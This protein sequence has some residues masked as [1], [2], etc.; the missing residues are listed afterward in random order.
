MK[1]RISGKIK[2]L[3][4]GLIIALVMAGCSNGDNEAAGQGEGPVEIE[5]WYGLGGNLGENMER[6]IEEFNSS[7][8]EVKVTGVAQG[9]YTET[10][11]KLQAA[12]A[13]K[14]V[15][16]AVLMGGTTVNALAEKEALAPMDSFIS[17]A[18]EFN[19]EDF[20]DSF[21]SQ[22][23]IDEKQYALP[24]YGTTQVMYYRDDVFKELGISTDDLSNWETLR[25]AAGK[26]KEEKGIF[27][28]MPMWGS[29][30]L[31]DAS[32]SRGGTIL[33]E[34]GTEVVIDSKEWIDTWEFFREAI[35][36]DETMGI[37]H[38]GQGW[39]YWYKTIDDVMQNR[40][41]GYTGSSGDQGDLDF[42]IVSAHP[43][44]G[45]ENSEAAPVA[46]ALLGTITALAPE[47]EQ[48]AAFKFL[49]FFTSAEITAD[50][51]VN[52][53]YIAVRDSAQDA[54]V[55]QDYAKE[56][57]QILV[58]LEQAKTASKP[59]IDPTGGKITDAIEKAADRVEIENIPAE[60]ALKEAKAEAQ[61]A[62]EEVLNQ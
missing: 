31:V 50:W 7:Q 52:T 45:W 20:I 39:E 32:L 61:I 48:K 38:S 43:Q 34:D 26:I 18:E 15:P 57:P 8:D 19:K 62:L 22:G 1:K 51:S 10:Y 12:I 58:P 27:G 5:F 55:F 60:E 28:W 36:E 35:H 9:N 54:P 3:L 17:E 29:G 46:D 4:M 6:L 40:A 23:Q 2:F 11:Q 21:Y 14:E 24:M 41:A 56:N 37:H 47:E 33:N 30:N 53:G 13:A 44:P 49:T 42:S 16:A 59:F 25:E